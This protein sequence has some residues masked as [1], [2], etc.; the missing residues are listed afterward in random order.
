M[1][2]QTFV[3]GVF[4]KNWITL[5]VKT[6][7]ARHLGKALAKEVYCE[8]VKILQQTLQKYSNAR[9]VWC[10]AGG[11]EGLDSILDQN[12]ELMEQSEGDLGQ[13]MSSFCEVQFNQG[14]QRVLIIGTDSLYLNGSDFDLAIQSL[15]TKS[16]VFQPSPDGGYTLVGMNKYTPEVFDSMPWSQPKL[17]QTTLNRIRDLGFDYDLLGQRND[18]DTHADLCEWCHDHDE[19]DSED[20]RL[21]NLLE[22][23]SKVC[24]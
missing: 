4:L 22:V 10:V 21:T 7:L 6:R 18:I 14:A 2:E 3:L 20:C 8:M 1:N 13:R 16:L 17:M 5:P 24:T 23:C 9:V 15:E 11:L 19:V 12:V